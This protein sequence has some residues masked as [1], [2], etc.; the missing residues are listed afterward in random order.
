MAGLPLLI[1]RRFFIKGSLAGIVG[2]IKGWSYGGD[3]GPTHWGELSTEY[4]ICGRGQHQ[5]PI[6]LDMVQARAGAVGFHYR[7]IEVNL[8]NN[9]RTIQ[10]T[11]DEHCTL[12]LD[13][14]VYQLLQFHFHTPSE[15]LHKGRHYPME[16]HLV[17]RHPAS[18]A[19]AVVGIWVT[20]G[21][22]QPEL[23]AMG[24]YLPP[25]PGKTSRAPRPINPA[26]LLPLDR[27]LVRYSGSLTTPPCSEGVTWLVMATPLEASV[28]QIEAFHRL[29]GNNARPLQLRLPL[30]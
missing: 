16:L 4:Q 25:Q 12:T 11:G 23:A 15:H 21:G 17:H 20:P 7:P 10:Q 28:Q 13:N 27:R 18:G 24:N 30:K 14:Q 2:Q 3:L 26:N 19:L 22:P 6:D 5:S 9:G 8:L 1:T 29:L